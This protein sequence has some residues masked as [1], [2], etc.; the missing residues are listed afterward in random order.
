MLFNVVLCLSFLFLAAAVVSALFYSLAI[1][2]NQTPTHST[3]SRRT[4]PNRSLSPESS[5]ASPTWRPLSLTRLRCLP[6]RTLP[7]PINYNGHRLMFTV[8]RAPRRALLSPPVP[9]RPKC[10]TSC[11]SLGSVL[12]G[13]RYNILNLSLRNIRFAKNIM[14]IL[15]CVWEGII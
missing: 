6:S 13:H 10:A 1:N 4:S 3:Y 8:A 2:Y 12:S 14:C 7:A 15:L 5:T 11:L 9:A